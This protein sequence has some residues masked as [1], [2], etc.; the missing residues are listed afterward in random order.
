MINLDT[1]NWQQLALN[2]RRHIPLSVASKKLGYDK[3]YLNRFARA[4]VVEPRFSKGIL[5]LN[6]HLDLCG[7]DKHNKLLTT[8]RGLQ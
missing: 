4:E 7:G 1:I 3:D 5:M 6:M 8:Y 2:L